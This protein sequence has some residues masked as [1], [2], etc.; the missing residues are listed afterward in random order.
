MHCTCGSTPQR[1]QQFFLTHLDNTKFD[2]TV[3]LCQGEIHGAITI[4]PKYLV[5]AIAGTIEQVR[6]QQSQTMPMAEQHIIMC[7]MMMGKNCVWLPLDRGISAKTKASLPSMRKANPHSYVLSNQI[8]G[9]GEVR[10]VKDVVVRAADPTTEAAVA[11][12]T[13][14]DEAEKITKES[15]TVENLKVNVT[16]VAWKIIMPPHAIFFLNCGSPSRTSELS[17]TRE[18]K[19]RLT[20]KEDIHTH[21]TETMCVHFKT[22]DSYRI[23]THQRITSWML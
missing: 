2:T 22:R 17:P 23:R 8:T 20:F 14:V 18:I 10:L 9:E 4:E 16:H 5:P 7:F 6:S 19:R 12:T 21:K 1:K 11:S 13:L 3:Q 15:T